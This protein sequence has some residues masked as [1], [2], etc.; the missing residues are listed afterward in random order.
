MSK[1]KWMVHIWYNHRGNI[2]IGGA[3]HSIIE[4]LSHESAVHLQWTHQVSGHY[5]EIFWDNP[6]P[7]DEFAPP[8]QN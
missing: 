8:K 7:I 2:A 4:N 1:D 5:V 3:P 6:E